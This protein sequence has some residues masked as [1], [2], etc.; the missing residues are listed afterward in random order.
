MSDAGSPTDISASDDPDD[1]LTGAT[2]RLIS[3]ESDEET[4]LF[5]PLAMAD[6]DIETLRDM[7]TEI[8][9]DELRGTLGERITRNLR[10]LVRREI[11]RVLIAEGL[12]RG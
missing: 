3:D 1:D 5:D 7:V 9:R 12:K 8:I 11:E 6:L 2:D 4:D 10:V